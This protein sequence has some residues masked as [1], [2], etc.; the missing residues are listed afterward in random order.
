MLTAGSCLPV[1][2]SGELVGSGFFSSVPGTA[3]KEL[4]RLESPD[5]ERGCGATEPGAI[6]SME[7]TS[8]LA[9]TP[10]TGLPGGTG[11]VGTAVAWAGVGGPPGS[12]LSGS[13]LREGSGPPGDWAS[14][15]QP[16]S[17]VVS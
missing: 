17:P 5:S 11:M 2:L 13:V 12:G 10:G 8:G 3:G 9:E 4:G 15:A 14:A 7:G 1:V 16:I 6:G